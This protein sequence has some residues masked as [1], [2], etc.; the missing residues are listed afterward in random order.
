MGHKADHE[1]QCSADKFLW[2]GYSL[3]PSL[4]ASKAQHAEMLRFAAAK[5]IKPTNQVFKFNG[6]ETLEDIF[7]K[8]NSNSVRYRA[9][10][11]L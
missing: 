1:T 3:Q 6:V 9:V 5:G 7:G 8:L 4:V 11:E 10:L 2:E